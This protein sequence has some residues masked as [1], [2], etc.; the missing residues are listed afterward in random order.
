MLLGVAR[1]YISKKKRNHSAGRLMLYALLYPVYV[2]LQ[3][4]GLDASLGFV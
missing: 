2:L 4:R 3:L 1:A